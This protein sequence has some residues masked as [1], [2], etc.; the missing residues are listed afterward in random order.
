MT[1]TYRV[2]WTPEAEADAAAIVEW[3]EDAINAERV[4]VQFGQRADSLAMFPERGRIVPE[5]KKIGVLTYHEIFHK[6]WRMIYVIRK[7][8]I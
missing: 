8:E 6:S 4:I 2:R 1:T 7:R 5:L 3:F